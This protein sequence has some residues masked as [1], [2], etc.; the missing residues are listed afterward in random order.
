VSGPRRPAA[1]AR[2]AHRLW[3]RTAL[4]ARLVAGALALVAVGLTV[5]GVV[6]VMLFRSYLV[7]QNGQQLRTVGQTISS[8][9]WDKPLHPGLICGALPND[10]AMELISEHGGPTAASSCPA[11]VGDA[12]AL[13][14]LPAQPVLDAAASSGEPFTLHDPGVHGLSWEA[15]VVRLVYRAPRAAQDGVGTAVFE[16]APPQDARD[17]VSTP[18]LVRSAPG[19]TPTTVEVHGYVLVATSMSAVDTPV[20]H[21]VDLDIAVDSAVG[22]AL[23]LLG[24]GI[25]RAALR[26]LAHI[27][28]AAE[29]ISAGDLSQRVPDRFPRTEIGRLSRALNGMLGQIETAFGARERSEAAARGSEQRMRRFVADAGHE[30]RTP[31][32]SIRGIAELYRQGAADSRQLPDLMRRI[33]DEAVRMGLLV[34]DLMVLARLDRQRPLARDPVH[35]AALALDAVAAAGA[36]APE[37]EV[38]LEVEPAAD[39][40]EPVVVGDETRLR[41]ALDNLVDNALRHTPGEARITVRVRPG[42]RGADPD[43]PRDAAPT[44]LLEVADTG[45]GLT[46]QAAEHVFERFYRADPSRARTGDGGSG[47]GLAI[48]AAIAQAHSGTVSVE[49]RYGYGALFR[50][51]LPALDPASGGWTDA[52]EPEEH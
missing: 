5:T 19:T 41:Q 45:P 48:V 31:L 50:L 20:A 9:H 18:P 44:C 27:E 51:T 43:R 39:G 2:R 14:Q 29:A 11:T 4:W 13:P 7:S 28:S 3:D 38:A 8:D 33:E 42:D 6:G 22:A 17:Q 21:L 46:P 12:T 47:L 35:L 24:Y 32:T 30:L 26:P 15:V 10:N 34:E 36:R 40:A 16:A 49:T 37:R 1:A 25:V 23:I 52:A